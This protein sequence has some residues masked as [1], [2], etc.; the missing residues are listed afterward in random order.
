MNRVL[1]RS[2]LVTTLSLVPVLGAAAEEPASPSA[3][4]KVTLVDGTEIEG[5]IAEVRR[6][7]KV[8]IVDQHGRTRT[9]EWARVADV[10]RAPPP[11]D[12]EES[13]EEPGPVDPLHLEITTDGRTTEVFQVVYSE[14]TGVSEQTT[15]LKNVCIAPCEAVIDRAEG[16]FLAFPRKAAIG[17][18]I[19]VSGYRDRVAVEVS[20]GRPGL[21]IGSM[22]VFLIGMGTLMSGTLNARVDGLDRRSGLAIGIG[23]ALVAGGITMFVMSRT[24]TW[25]K[26][27]DG[28]R[29]RARRR[30]EKG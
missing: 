29:Q 22:P 3:T 18:A 13:N 27:A 28:T 4:D 23:T 20:P 5:T 25:I 6:D 21:L 10:K 26:G 16:N 2:V 17:A 12:P 24:R 7:E 14:R 9:I 30:R 1:I 8:V 19:D 15:V 11:P